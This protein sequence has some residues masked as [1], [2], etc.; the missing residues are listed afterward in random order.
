MVALSYHR[1]DTY[2]FHAVEMIQSL[3][4]H[5]AG[6][7][8]GIES[9]QCLTGEAV[10]EAGRQGVYDRTLLDAALAR[11]ELRKIPEGKTVEDLVRKG[12]DLFVVD[13]A[14]GFRACI[15]T[16]NGAVAE[17]VAAW[18]EEGDADDA[19]KSTIF[20]TQE[21]RPYYHFAHL[22]KGIETMMIEKKATWPVERT[23]LSSGLLDAALISKRDGGKELQTPWLKAIHYQSAWNWQQP[24]PPPPDQ[25]R[26]PRKKK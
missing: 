4:E 25:P 26:P 12:P 21:A 20:F 9:V 19:I 10:W 11:M 13:Y 22:M 8:T 24:P 23:L 3:A 17:W 7:E 18:R 15:F 1:L 16:L 6:G 5:R 2:G 14:D